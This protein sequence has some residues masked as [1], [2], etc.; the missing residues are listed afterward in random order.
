MLAAIDQRDDDGFGDVVGAFAAAIKPPPALS[1]SEWAEGRLVIP[2]ETGT[3]RPGPL[4]WEG[5]E[6]IREPLDRLHP[7]DPCRDVTFCGSAQIAK[8]NIGIVATDYYSA[9]VPR[10]WCVALP[11]GDEV[12]KYNRTKWQPIRDATPELR[13]KV[14]A[15]SS[16]DEQGSTNTF[17]KFKG[18]FGSFIAA[19][20]AKALQMVSFCLVVKEETPNWELEVGGRGDPHAQLRFRQLQWE[21]AGAKTFHNSTPGFVDRCPVTA[22]FLK[23]DQRRLY[24]P[25]PHCGDFLRLDWPR[26]QGVKEGDPYF[27][28][29]HCSGRIEHR[30]KRD[31]VRAS[32][33]LPTF[34]SQDTNNPAPDHFV[35][36]AALDRWRAR[37]VEGRQPSYHAWQVVSPAVDWRYIAG[38]AIGAEEGTE[39]VKRTFSQQVLGE[40]CE[41]VTQKADIEKL[42]E[43]REPGTEGLVPI[44][45]YLLFGMVDLN[46]DFAQWR[47]WG[48]GAGLECWP[49]AGGV[50]EGSPN[51][52]SMWA[53]IRKVIARDYIHAEGGKL[54]VESW[55]IDSGYGT[56]NV[57]SFCSK[58]SHVK[59]S[60]GRDGW[61]LAPLKRGDIQRV[62]GPDGVL[63]SAR[64]WLIGTW[65]L[66]RTLY[67]CLATT[68]QE[69]DEE[70]GAGKGVGI[71]L[72]LHLPEF[73]L[74]KP[75]QE[76]FDRSFLEELTAETLET[77]ID[78]KT[79]VVSNERWQRNRRRNEE[80]DLF[81]G[82]TAQA[83]ARGVGVPG[84]EPDWVELRRRCTV[85][86]EADLE[87]FWS[88][89]PHETPAKPVEALEQSKAED[90]GARAAR[91]A[92]LY[93][94]S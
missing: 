78:K 13:S 36:A 76:G 2:G 63:A 42:L 53:E 44:G 79:G 73:V 8:T 26:M 29:P 94:G 71:P 58:Y 80:M 60:D 74:R 70:T 27:I 33:W 30:H 85:A 12:M 62:R 57:Y 45:A 17:K 87:E 75:G 55:L 61:G 25:C 10:P 39:A 28:C 82:C 89:P 46:G 16:R 23:G 67:E 88:R 41:L 77:K 49:I 18:G 7:D 83:K 43:K 4:S 93:G 47:V 19:S 81:V 9:A 56:A 69:R 3:A 84:S 86:R 72:K 91:L 24:H 20:S 64:I 54:K 22:D 68:L 37:D 48:Y 31:M 34:P 35:A 14:R 92:A 1:I 90:A 59:A 50:I 65:D 11:S 38:E 32:V 51:D 52:L 40:A 6:Y 5:F 15:V 66:K 21:L